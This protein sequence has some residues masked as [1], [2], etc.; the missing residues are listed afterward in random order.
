MKSRNK[1]NQLHFMEN[2]SI[3]CANDC[4][5]C[6]KIAKMYVNRRREKL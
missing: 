6:V 1:K 4:V 2:K 3:I 5:D